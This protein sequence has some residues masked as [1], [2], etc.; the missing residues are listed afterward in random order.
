MIAIVA[1]GLWKR[2]G[3]VEALRGV[4]LKVEEGRVMGLLGPN[5]AGKTTL[6]RI[7]TT[8]LV[9]DR[10]S[11]S[12]M[13]HDVVREPAA[14]RR[15]IGL[16]GQYAA[17]DENLTG[18]ENLEMVGRLYHLPTSE[19]RRKADALLGLFSLSDAARRRAKT[20]SGGMRRRLDLAATLVGGPK[21][22]FLDE[23]TTGLDPR[24]RLELWQ[25]IRDL[26]STGVTVLLTTQYL[27]E[28][29]RL[30][31]TISIIDGGGI[32][33]QGTSAELKSR[34]GGQV[35]TIRLAESS[36]AVS[37]ARDLRPFGSQAPKV[38][39]TTGEIVLSIA[40]GAAA[41]PEVMRRLGELGVAVSDL[42]CRH[43]TLDDVFLSL[44]GRRAQAG[45][46]PQ[47]PAASPRS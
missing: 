6:V 13:G 39:E 5:G 22:L 20:Y 8:L 3:A 25:N 35:L 9:P 33:A 30:A 45:S 23:P 19:A 40:G 34:V 17:V 18:R 41:V 46:T 47:T 42:S 16:A 24:S 15:A 37:V 38:E 2:F 28:A 26:V 4:E 44:T 27:E 29:D 31:N 14:V 43:P 7:L 36:Q 10:G 12:V 11:A 32:I 21:V 1:E